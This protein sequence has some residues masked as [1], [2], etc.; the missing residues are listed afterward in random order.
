[1]PRP[2]SPMGASEANMRGAGFV[3]RMTE[4]SAVLI[5]GCSSGIGLAA[6]RRLIAGGF[7]VYAGVRSESDGTRI[8]S[9]LGA[10]CTP[11]RLDVTSPAEIAAAR[12]QI[13]A[14]GRGLTGLV[15]NAGIVVGG[16]LEAVTIADL[17]GV[18]EINVIGLVAV[19]QAVLPLLRASRGRIVNIGS[20]AGRF[21]SPFMAPYSASKFAVEA[22]SDAARVELAPFGIAVALL[23]PGA[24]DTPI[25]NKA[26]ADGGVRTAR[27]D[28]E[29]R[30][31][32]G[33]IEAAMETI[34]AGIAKRALPAEHVARAIEHALTARRPKARYVIGNDAR[35]QL[36]L[37]MLPSGLRDRMLGYAL[38]KATA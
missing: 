21:A 13:D 20:V 1:M 16:P 35:A 5:T 22:I 10:A 15:N 33:P 31:L 8:A 18:L 19:T 9:D 14:A 7:H 6:A 2:L 29:M 25:W 3:G 37:Q 12:A 26:Q 36:A 11:I 4:S 38:A 32:Y 30:R 28:G 27:Y 34:V 24:I 17:R 23:E